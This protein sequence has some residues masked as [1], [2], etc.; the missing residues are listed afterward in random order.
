MAPPVPLSVSFPLDRYHI[1]GTALEREYRRQAGQLARC[2]LDV[3]RLPTI[4]LAHGSA[5]ACRRTFGG[6]YRVTLPKRHGNRATFKAAYSEAVARA[7]IDL[8]RQQQ[9][10]RFG[11]IAYQFDQSFRDTTAA[12]TRYAL[13]T[14]CENR[15]VAVVVLHL[16]GRTVQ[17][18]NWTQHATDNHPERLGLASYGTRKDWQDEAAPLLGEITRRG[19]PTVRAKWAAELAKARTAE[20]HAIEEWQATGRFSI[21]RLW[22]KR[23]IKRA[24]ARAAL[25]TETVN[26]V[27]MLGE[28]FGLDRSG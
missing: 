10:D 22:A 16:F 13:T 8:L 24:T 23:K 11:R 15:F 20:R 7:S 17:L 27:R 1:S 19:L 2:G 21:R 9:P 18:R 25:V 28:V 26:K 5:V 4:T 12:L 14:D 6:N 3:S